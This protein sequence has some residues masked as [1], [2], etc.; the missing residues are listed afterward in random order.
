MEAIPAPGC[1][2]FPK[3]RLPDATDGQH[4]GYNS[5]ILGGFP[6]D[7]QAACTVNDGVEETTRHYQVL[8]E[9]RHI[10]EIT[11]R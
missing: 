5:G 3:M 1:Y 4:E 2:P 6:V 8:I 7:T 10:G 9:M 11:D